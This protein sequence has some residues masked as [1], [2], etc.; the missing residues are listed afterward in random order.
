MH[1]TWIKLKNADELK[2]NC[3]CNIHHRQNKC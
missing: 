2:E 1:C 3:N